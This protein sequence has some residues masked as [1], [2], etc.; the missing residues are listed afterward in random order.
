[1]GAIYAFLVMAFLVM[2]F[3]QFRLILQIWG[4][5]WRAYGFQPWQFLR[6]RRPLQ[7]ELDRWR[8]NPEAAHLRGKFRKAALVVIFSFILFFGAVLCVELTLPHVFDH[9]LMQL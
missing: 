3:F 1:L 7:R 9:T 6:T 2:M 4:V 5:I 8:A